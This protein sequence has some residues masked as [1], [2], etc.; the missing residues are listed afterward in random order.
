MTILAFLR[1]NIGRKRGFRGSD[2]AGTGNAE[3]RVRI[4][5][6]LF[7]RPGGT[8]YA[9]KRRR[10]IAGMTLVEVMVALFIFGISIAGTCSL[11]FQSRRLVDRSRDHYTAINIG[12]NRLEK[13]RSTAFD[14]LFT[15]SETNVLVNY[16][17]DPAADSNYRRS[18]RVTTIS[19]NLIEM[20]VRVDIKNRKNWSWTGEKEEIKSYYADMLELPE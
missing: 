12:K 2:P 8:E 7:E 19:S 17:G 10:Q 1:R 6:E 16:A 18:T 15:L 20:V 4:A 13:G 11:V 5:I 14:L 3:I 9:M